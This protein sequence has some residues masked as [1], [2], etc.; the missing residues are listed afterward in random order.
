MYNETCEDICKITYDDRISHKL[1]NVLLSRSL[2][3]VRYLSVH[4]SSCKQVS[5]FQNLTKYVCYAGCFSP[6]FT[7]NKLKIH[8]EH[9][10]I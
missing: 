10:N 3:T 8:A 5:A 1:Q 2:D 9:I 7:Q 6:Y 4:S